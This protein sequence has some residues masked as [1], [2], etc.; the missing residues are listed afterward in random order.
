MTQLSPGAGHAF[1][2]SPE[3]EDVTP[4]KLLVNAQGSRRRSSTSRIRH[5]Q[6]REKNDFLRALQSQRAVPDPIRRSVRKRLVLA[7]AL[8]RRSEDQSPRPGAEVGRSSGRTSILGAMFYYLISGAYAEP[9][10]TL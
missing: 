10:G 6:G 2:Q 4:S 3:Q 5:P 1:L 9:E 7:T 8:P